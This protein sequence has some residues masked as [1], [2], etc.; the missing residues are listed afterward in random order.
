MDS[1]H[2]LGASSFVLVSKFKA[3]KTDLKRWN[4]EVFSNVER[5]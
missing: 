3:L 5:K 2:F 1:Y 4:K